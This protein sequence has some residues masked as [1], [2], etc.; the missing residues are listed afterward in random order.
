MK[1]NKN[2]TLDI[3]IVEKLSKIDNASKVVNDLLG[4]FLINS[5]EKDTVFEQKTALLKQNKAKMKQIKAE[6]K[7]FTTLDKLN[8]DQRCINWCFNKEF[9]YTDE[10]IDRYKFPR[11]IKISIDNFR[12]CAEL[13]EKNVSLFKHY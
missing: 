8:F 4:E 12:K 10:D 7:I 2:F 11:Q 3:D 13:V 9:I 1:I 6:I 5:N